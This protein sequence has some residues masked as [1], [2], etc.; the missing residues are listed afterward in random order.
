[1]VPTTTTTTTTTPIPGVNVKVPLRRKNTEKNGFM[2][3]LFFCNF[4][5]IWSFGIKPYFCCEWVFDYFWYGMFIDL[6]FK[7]GPKTYVQSF[8]SSLLFRPCSPGS[9]FEDSLAPFDT[10]LAPRWSFLL[11]FRIYLDIITIRNHPFGTRICKA[12]VEEPQ[13]NSSQ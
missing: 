5:F 7:R 1:M 9:A 8:P 4:Y 12:P 13:K 6:W 10:L 11:L 3:L 2:M